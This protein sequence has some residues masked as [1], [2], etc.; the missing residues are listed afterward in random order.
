MKGA[1][2]CT[3]AL[4][5]GSF[6]AIADDTPASVPDGASLYAEH[7]QVCHGHKGNGRGPA[8]WAL[9]PKPTDFTRVDYWSIDVEERG[10]RALKGGVVNTS[11][12]PY[13][14]LDAAEKRAVLAYLGLFQPPAVAAPDPAATAVQ[15]EP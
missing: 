1:W 6:S 11:M 15:D 10:L 5:F 4:A 2:S 3:L 14:E 9:K 7:C 8:F 12:R 13:S